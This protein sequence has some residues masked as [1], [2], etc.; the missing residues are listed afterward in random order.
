MGTFE[1]N[2]ISIVAGSTVGVGMRV[3][4]RPPGS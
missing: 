2:S 4:L 3:T 1:P